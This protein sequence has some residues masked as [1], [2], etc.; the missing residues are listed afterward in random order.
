[1]QKITTNNQSNIKHG[2]FEVRNFKSNQ[3][4][5][6]RPVNSR[7]HWMSIDRTP[8]KIEGKT[9]IKSIYETPSSK[10]QNCKKILLIEER[11]GRFMVSL[12]V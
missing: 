4:N 9:F 1:M 2:E 11:L 6:A 7:N 3:M 10:L 8:D 5:N 12:S